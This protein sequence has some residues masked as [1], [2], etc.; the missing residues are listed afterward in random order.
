MIPR[1][2]T[3]NLNLRI[4]FFIISRFV[5]KNAQNFIISD[6]RVRCIRVVLMRSSVGHTWILYRGF[7]T[8]GA[9]AFRLIYRGG[10]VK[11]YFWTTPRLELWLRLLIITTI[12]IFYN[13]FYE[14]DITDERKKTKKDFGFRAKRRMCSVLNRTS[15][16]V[17]SVRFVKKLTNSINY[18][19]DA[20]NEKKRDF[21]QHCIFVRD[22]RERS[23]P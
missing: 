16:G 6:W 13:P 7:P 10:G 5:W 14:P 18:S 21:R 12:Y 4:P 15:A 17:E 1:I 11:I 8:W 9:R 2:V 23:T 22:A 3:R 20:R 19:P